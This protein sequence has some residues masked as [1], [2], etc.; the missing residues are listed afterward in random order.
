M[1]YSSAT[2]YL[3]KFNKLQDF[4]E[5]YHSKSTPENVPQNLTQTY[6]LSWDWWSTN[7]SP[8]N[9]KFVTMC[10]RKAVVQGIIFSTNM[11]QI[12]ILVHSK[13]EH[14]LKYTLHKRCSNNQAEQLAIFKA[15]ETIEKS[16]IN[17]S[18]LRKATVHTDSRITLHSQEHKKPQ[19]PHRR[20]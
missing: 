2:K 14:Q 3:K 20:N 5:L 17:N 11:T 4:F 19:L 15:L 18:I 10:D 1:L 12:W 13:L 7:E 8:V 9:V 16:H 6:N